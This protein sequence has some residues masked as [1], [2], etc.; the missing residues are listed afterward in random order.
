M[1]LVHAVYGNPSTTD[2]VLLTNNRHC[3]A[4]SRL[5]PAS[6]RRGAQATSSPA[7]H[8]QETEERATP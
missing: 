3:S 4:P 8:S 2:G 6:C 7:E 5:S 1:V